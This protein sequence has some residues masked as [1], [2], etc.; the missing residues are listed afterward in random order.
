MGA[1]KAAGTVQ[2]Q[3]RRRAGIHIERSQHVPEVEPGSKDTQPHLVRP[4]TVRRPGHQREP[5]DAAGLHNRQADRS[6]DRR[7]CRAIMRA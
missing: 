1:R 6:P 7:W 5:V 2:A 3:R 4:Q